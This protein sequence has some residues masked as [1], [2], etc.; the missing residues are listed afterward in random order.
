MSRRFLTRQLLCGALL[1]SLAHVPVAHADDAG[2]WLSQ[3]LW[4]DFKKPNKTHGFQLWLDLHERAWGS[5]FLAIVRPGLG[6]D[7]GHGLTFWGGYAF[8]PSFVHNT[9]DPPRF[10]HRIWEQFIANGKVK[11]VA[12]QGRIRLEQRFRDGVDGVGERLRIFGRAGFFFGQQSSWGWAI[13]DELLINLNETNAWPIGFDQNRFFTGPFVQAQNGVRVEFGYFNFLVNRRDTGLYDSHIA[14][15]NLFI[16]VKAFPKPA[17]PRPAEPAPPPAPPAAPVDSS[18]PAPGA[19]DPG[20][21]APGAPPASPPA[22]SVAPDSSGGAAS[23][24]NVASDLWDTP[25]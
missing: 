16:P 18:P 11:T 15:M 17:P 2:S 8:I 4:V 20:A 6:Y 10:E 21:P 23:S 25:S 7:I 24:P 1:G 19:L 9:T 5:T 3:W 13:W 12:L 14:M 22:P